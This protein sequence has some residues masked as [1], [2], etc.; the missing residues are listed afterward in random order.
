MITSFYAAILA[1]IYIVL[2]ACVIY[3]R[4]SHKIGLSDGGNEDL[5]RRIRIHGNFA[6]YVP[7]ALLLLFFVDDGGG[8]PV[9]IH[10][11]G[12]MLVTGRLLHAMGLCQSAGTSPGRMVG[13]I[14]TFLVILICALVLL[15]NFFVIQFT[16][17]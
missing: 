16:R 1:L 17:F 13:M 8:S 15:W 6:E 4:Y 12:V 5:A 14:L 2:A 11:M 9:F 3:G 10:L 7:I